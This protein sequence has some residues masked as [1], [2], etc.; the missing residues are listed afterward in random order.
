[1]RASRLLRPVCGL[2]AWMAVAGTLGRAPAG[3]AGEPSV[4][5]RDVAIAMRDG[6]VLRANVWRPAAAGPFPVLVYRTPYGKDATEEWYS[7]HRSAV[8]RG[9]AVVLQDVRGRYASEG[10]FEPYRNEGRDGYDS[11]EWAAAQP[12]SDSRVGTFGLSYPGAVQWL[13]ALEAPPHLLAMAPAMTFASPRM[14]F[15]ANGVWDLSWLAWI[16]NSIAPDLRRRKNL[17]GPLSADES[18]KLWARHASRMR[19][20]LP[21]LELPDLRDVAP[22]YYEWLRHPPEDPW[23]DW[24]ELRG[25]YSR[26][27]AAVLLLSGW[28]DEAYGPEGATTNFRGLWQARAG[29]ADRRTRLVLGPWTHGV[30]SLSRS[31]VG[32][33]DFGASAAI[34]YDALVLDWMDRYV[35]GLD[36]G[37]D[38]RPAVEYFVM[39]ADRWRQ[40]V[41]W[42]PPGQAEVSLFL[43]A[44]PPER[45]IGALQPRPPRETEAFSTI[46]SDPADPLVDPYPTFGAH[47]YRDLGPQPY[48]RA[49]ERR[50]L[51][52]FDSL[53]LADELEVAGALRAEIFVSCDCR[54]TDLWVKVLDVAPDG[55]ALNLMSPGLDVVRAS[56][57]QPQRGRQLLEPGEVYRLNL[58]HLLTANR[59][60]AGHRVRVI[61]T[62]SF[63]PHF[64]RNLH[65]GE[66]EAVSARMQ[67][68]R[69]RIHHDARHRSRLVLPVA[70]K[71]VILPAAHTPADDRP[72]GLL[73][74]RGTDNP[75]E[76]RGARDEPGSR[77][78]G[79]PFNRRRRGD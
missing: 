31:R 8:A 43:A 6:V 50:D 78:G 64:S 27:K 5:E 14:F 60:R 26:V 18:R 22:F 41:S 49:V 74:A 56:L 66:S 2:L 79:G 16:H 4:V 20:H 65:T 28:H 55:T 76:R 33:R 70:R 37:V 38:R 52:V 51:L 53:P 68:A 21:L 48:R 45:A 11:I 12:W 15:Y 1:M 61:L 58:D 46:V 75:G 42:P 40:A 39:G 36:N 47:D 67:T 69:L 3:A 13:A 35:R 23:W 54:D 10:E 7:T 57:R 17:P 34:D 32:E 44:P 19:R 24:A 29:Q 77:I 63:F 72:A 9:Y 30:E 59:F 73:Q 25:R 71:P 62:T